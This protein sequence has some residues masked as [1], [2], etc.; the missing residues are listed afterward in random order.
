MHVKCKNLIYDNVS[1]SVSDNVIETSTLANENKILYAV[2]KSVCVHSRQL[3]TKELD[4]LAKDIDLDL[5]QIQIQ[6]QRKT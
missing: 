5:D 6:I 3:S 2:R 1:D 4:Q